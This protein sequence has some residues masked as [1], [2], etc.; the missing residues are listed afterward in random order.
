MLITEEEA[1]KKWCP[2][3]R[4]DGSN[5][6]MLDTGYV[7]YESSPCIVSGCMMWRWSNKIPYESGKKVAKKGYCGLGGKP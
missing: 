5:A 6:S 7:V 4:L 2:E 1:K 3:L